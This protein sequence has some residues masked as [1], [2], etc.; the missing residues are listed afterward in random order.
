MHYLLITS[1]LWAFSF[2]LVKK[3]LMGVDAIALSVLRLAI[4]TVIFLPLLR[5]RRIPVVRGSAWR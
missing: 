1:L 2:A 5:A 3:E 4:A